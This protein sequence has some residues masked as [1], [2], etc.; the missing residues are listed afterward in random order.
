MRK[1]LMSILFLLLIAGCGRGNPAKQGTPVSVYA[2]GGSDGRS[3]L[4]EMT[5]YCP[6]GEELLE[7]VLNEVLQGADS[8]FPSGVDATDFELEDGMAAVTLSEEAASLEGFALTLAR[9]GLVLTLTGLDGI[10]VVV[11]TIEGATSEPVT[12]RASDFVLS[13]L[14]LADT[15]R[16][17]VLYF[18]DQT[19]ETVMAETRTLVVRETDTVAW[20]VRYVIDELIKGP[21]KAGLQAVMPEGTTLLSVF[22]EGD[23]WTVNLSNEFAANA[24]NNGIS[25]RMTLHCLVRSVT[26]QP[27][28]SAMRLWVDGQS[29]DSYGD[30]DTSEPLTPGDVRLEG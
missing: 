16:S 26:T 27:E 8:P 28:I 2:L 11:L 15:E 20:Y 9:A 14:V 25:A 21:Q 1:F 24:G 6:E 22:P 19:G 7:F 18:S 4:A 5:R 12:L 10:D 23:V 3:A 30:V 29:I 13:P 17:I